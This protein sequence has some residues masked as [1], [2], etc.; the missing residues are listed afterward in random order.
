M[1]ILA[2]E[3]GKVL[4]LSDIESTISDFDENEKIIKDVPTSD[5]IRN[6]LFLTELGI[7]RL[8]MNSKKNYYKTIPNVVSKCGFNYL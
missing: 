4:R 3:I 8:L 7:F 1:Y 6:I 2:S 5:G